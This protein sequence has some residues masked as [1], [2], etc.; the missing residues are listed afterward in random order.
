MLSCCRKV[1]FFSNIHFK[2]LFLAQHLFL[3]NDSQFFSRN[4]KNPPSLMPIKM[5]EMEGIL[6]PLTAYSTHCTSPA[7]HVFPPW[8]RSALLGPLLPS[9]LFASLC[10]RLSAP[11]PGRDMHTTPGFSP[12]NQ[13]LWTASLSL[14]AA[15][16]CSVLSS[17][18]SISAA[19]KEKKTGWVGPLYLVF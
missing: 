3:E 4:Q 13:R 19:L 14:A 11:E 17:Q 1:L 15:S 2:V 10:V 5:D 6:P 7:D 18:S 9:W 8:G 12:S 16:T